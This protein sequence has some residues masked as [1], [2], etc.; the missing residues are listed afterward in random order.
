MNCYLFSCGKVEIRGPME[1]YLR[2]RVLKLHWSLYVNDSHKLLIY[3]KW[4][5][6][7]LLPFAKLW[8]IC[9]SRLFRTVWNGPRTEDV[10]GSLEV[11]GLNVEI[12]VVFSFSTKGKCTHTHTPMHPHSN[13]HTHTHTHSITI[14]ET[15]TQ[16]H[17]HGTVDLST[18]SHLCQ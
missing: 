15:N 13:T 8:Q 6:S 14:K 18:W 16:A 17:M 10:L 7:H 11:L 1:R 4:H 5:L 3:E 12:L 2:K 9:K